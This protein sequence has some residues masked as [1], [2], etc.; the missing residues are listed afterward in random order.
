VGRP[1]S[2]IWKTEARIGVLTSNEGAGLGRTIDFGVIDE[3]LL[4]V[5]DRRDSAILPAMSTRPNSQ[6]LIIWKRWG[7]PPRTPPREPPGC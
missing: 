7:L 2:I 5:D 4:D 3:A 1:Q 6:L